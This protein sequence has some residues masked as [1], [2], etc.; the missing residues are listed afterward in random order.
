MFTDRVVQEQIKAGQ[1]DKLQNFLDL[2][3]VATQARPSFDHYLPL[4]YAAGAVSPNEMPRFF[5][6]GFRQLPFQCVL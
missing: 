6:A 4:L 3:A 1:L 2:G 5:N